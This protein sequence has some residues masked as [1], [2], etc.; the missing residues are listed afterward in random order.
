MANLAD[1]ARLSLDDTSRGTEYEKG[2]A[3]FAAIGS[4]DLESFSKREEQVL[5]LHDQL[6]ELRLEV[7]L[8]E[9]LENRPAGEHEVCP[10]SN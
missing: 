6:E 10:S 4:H 1:I 9:G 3:D 7:A 2:F 5:V 8:S